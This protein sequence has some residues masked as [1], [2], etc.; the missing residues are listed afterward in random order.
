MSP[1]PWWAGRPGVFQLAGAA[2]QEAVVAAAASAG[3]AVYVLPPVGSKAEFLESLAATLRFPGWSGRNWD[4]AA[5]L[6]GDLSWLPNTPWVLVW[7]DAG[8]LKA[9]DPGAYGV[10]RGILDEAAAARRLTVLLVE[11]PRRGRS[12]VDTRRRAPI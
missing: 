1:G 11:A 8:R 12:G 6:L 5:D 7:V 9:A 2:S 4:A 3:I 10:A